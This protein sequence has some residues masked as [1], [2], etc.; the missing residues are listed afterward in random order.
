MPRHVLLNNVAHKDLRVI[1]R[2]GP[3]FGDNVGSVLT[4]P[5]E[6]EDMQRE[7]PIFFRKDSS[8]GEYQPIA[9][10]GFEKGENLFVENGYWN[11]SY[12]PGVIMRGPFLIGFQQ[13]VVDGE[14]RKDPVIHIDLDHPRV[15]QTEGE[16]VFLPQG[17][18]S[19]YL[20]HMAMVLRGIHDGIEVSKAM[21]AEFTALD[22]LE[23]VKLEIKVNTEEAYNVVGLHTINRAKLSALDG[24]TLE[25]LNRSGFLYGAY[26]VLASLNNVKR[27]MAIKQRRKAQAAG[28]ATA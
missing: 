24:A 12:V 4:F 15:S 28:R 5:T 14:E 9:L 18:N 10:L 1:N 7:Y 11:A 3:E 22:L 16:R 6:F 21:F 25:R 8:T 17:G 20:E 13:K 27:L 19:P 2:Y 26:L 23:P